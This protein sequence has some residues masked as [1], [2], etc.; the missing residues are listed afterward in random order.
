MPVPATMQAARYVAGSGR[1]ELREVPVP[2][3]GDGEVLVRVEACGICLSDVHLLD[4]SLPTQ[5]PEVT[6]GHEASGVVA[7]VGP[8]VA[9]WQVGDAVVLSGGRPCRHCPACARGRFDE[10]AQVEIMGFA[11]DGAWAQY[12]AVPALGLTPRPTGLDP[13][14]AAIC[15]DAVST[16][17]AG[18]I[19][20]AQLR[21]G[22][23]VGL[24]GIGG[25]GVHAVQIARFAGAGHIIAIDP[26]AAARERALALG[27]DTAL[28]PT[29]LDVTAEVS[30]LTG[31]R[32]L[33]LAVDLVGANAVLAAGAACLGRGGRVLMVGLSMDP[34]ELG[35]GLLFGLSSHTLLG[36]LGYTKADLDDVVELAGR[37]RL[38]LSRSITDRIPLA[39]VGDGVERLRSKDGDPIR[40]VVMP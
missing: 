32:G 10:C 22:E 3:P 1:V 27:A 20:R 8:A 37:G 35:M 19:R 39:D 24:W 30:A 4:G 17:Y 38:D 40:I 25:L 12:V 5:L 6:P 23:R 29:D 18:I 21:P 26:S 11:Y 34:I 7:A 28:D 15:A 33:D 2:Q 36:H 14:E 9:V 13:A 16:P 31:G